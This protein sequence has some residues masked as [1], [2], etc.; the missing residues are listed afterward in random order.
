M[1][2]RPDLDVNGLS[3]RDV[4]VLSLLLAGLETK[5]IARQLGIGERG[6][7][8]YRQRLHVASQTH[9][10]AQ[11]GYWACVRGYVQARVATPVKVRLTAEV[12][13]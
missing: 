4:E 12:R 2:A 11:L 7:K 6:V 13:T 1:P 9:R 5:H 10:P 8:F 3:A